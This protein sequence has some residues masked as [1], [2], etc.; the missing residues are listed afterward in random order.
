MKALGKKWASEFRSAF[1]V[2]QD[3][4]ESRIQIFVMGYY[5]VRLN[6]DVQTTVATSRS[7]D[8]Y[9]YCCILS[10]NYIK[11]TQ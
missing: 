2:L 11:F 4:V 1:R 3:Q 10:Y 5:Y 7:K 9:L 6:V 8:F